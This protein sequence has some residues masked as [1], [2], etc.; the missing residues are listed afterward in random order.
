M[1]QAAFVETKGINR[2]YEFYRQATRAV[3][4]E[5]FDARRVLPALIEYAM[6]A[7]PTSAAFSPLPKL[8]KYRC[9]WTI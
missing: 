4:E 9:W 7:A 8:G 6:D 3:A 1:R 2:H 5:R